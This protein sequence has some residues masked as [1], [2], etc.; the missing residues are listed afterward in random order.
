MATGSRTS[1][2]RP[3]H[4]YPL[5]LTDPSPPTR[6]WPGA[7]ARWLRRACPG[8]L[9]ALLLGFAT[10][11][12]TAGGDGSPMPSGSLDPALVGA[13]TLGDRFYPTLGNGGYDV[14]H[15]DLDLT[16]HAPDG[17]HE[18]GLVGGRARIALVTTHRL[19][20]LSLDLGG[21]ATEVS[22]V[23]VDGVVAR[24]GRD[25]LRR[26]LLVPLG[27]PL[28]RGT[29]LVIDVDW[30]TEPGGAHRLG[31]GMT[32]PSRARDRRRVARGLLPDGDGGF[33]LAS[34]PN[35]AHTLF[36]SNDHPLDKATFTVRL[37]AP[38]GMLGV[39][40]GARVSQ[41]AHDDGSVTT[42]W[43]SGAPVATHVL[44][45]GV[46]RMALIEADPR[47]GPHLRSAVPAA[48]A[49]VSGYRLDDITEAVAWLESELGLPLPFGSIGVQLAPLGAT[50]AVLE[51]QT[52][53]VA[54]AELLDPQVSACAWRALLVHEVAHQWFG[55]SVSLVGWDEK[56]L[57]EGHATWYQRRFE[58][59]SG[60]DRLGFEGRMTR[61]ARGA[62]AARDAGGPPARP[63]LPANAYDATVYDQGALALEALRRE[64]GDPTFRAIERA[65][66]DRYRDASAS[67]G[68]FIALASEVAG[69]DLGPFLDAWLRADRVPDLAP[70][71]DAPP[72]S[73]A[74]LR[75]AGTEP[76]RVSEE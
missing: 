59:A 13:R 7:P 34:Q 36:P 5:A 76:P 75:P 63:R 37:T 30:T 60:C 27:R 69:R 73:A 12:P 44:A 53:I 67:T 54:G 8:A 26:K 22:G 23:R 33:L 4:R 20:E 56:W 39:A 25:A 10:L 2:C 31:E 14:T 74:I 64:V 15:Y 42:T 72:S 48:L 61:I 28:P 62:Q 21:A 17:A 52:L 1:A 58:A 18:H 29:G 43:A 46:G 45:M 68:Q 11:A 16:W 38:A 3:A 35:G 41:V 57:S 32:L 49:P 24:H 50:D 70:G 51:G 47:D 66:L 40:T 9:V 55:D 65:W 19:A 6:P 71:P